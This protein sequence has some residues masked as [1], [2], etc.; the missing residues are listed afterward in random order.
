MQ[1]KLATYLI[2]AGTDEKKFLP[3]FHSRLMQVRLHDE[4][5]GLRRFPFSLSNSESPI[6]GII[7]SSNKEKII[8]T[9]M[10]EF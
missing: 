9:R 4:E 6:I 2:E 10:F 1:E 3:K 7:I 8:L 5:K